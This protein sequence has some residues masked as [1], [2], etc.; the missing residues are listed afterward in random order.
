[1]PE[2][3]VT[4]VCD[5]NREGGGYLSVNWNMCKEQKTG[6]R[7]PARRAVDDFYAQQKPSG[8]YRGCR[9][10]NDFRELLAKEKIDAVMIA[11]PDHTH[12]VI[13]MAAIKLGKHVYCE[14]PLT[15]SVAEAR[16]V[17]E[18]A[19]RAGVATQLGNA[20][21]ASEEARLV[22]EYILDGA[23][24][25]VREIQV[26]IGARFWPYPTWRGR[27][28]ETPPVPAW[29]RLGPVA[30]ACSRAPLS[31]GLLSLDLA[32]LVGFRD[33]AGR[34]PRLPRALDPLQGLEADAPRQRRGVEHAQR[35][36]DSPA[37]SDR[38]FRV[39]RARRDAPA[40]AHLVRRWLEA[41]TPEGSRTGAQR[42][43]RHLHWRQGDAHGAP[44]DPRV[45]D[46]G[47]RPPAQEARRVPR[48]TSRSSSTPAAAA[49][50]PVPISPIMPAF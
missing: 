38:P 43:R 5:V 25:P 7:E 19:R 21:Q 13:T 20:G 30:G 12:A 1:M 37:W 11:T 39:P 34:R 16:Q 47:L 22:Q 35:L 9:A 4:A 36:R 49:R 32:Q 17:A 27:P 42:R 15:H 31:S 46:E 10:Y 33:R 3:Q 50:P 41:R 8:K 6:G 48:A 2:V 29:P 24:G 18:A 44:L 40:D 28:Q 45:A 26:A 23:I 14:K